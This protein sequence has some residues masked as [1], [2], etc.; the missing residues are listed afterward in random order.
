MEG[1]KYYQ[2]DDENKKVCKSDIDGDFIFKIYN[3]HSYSDVG[4]NIYMSL[5]NKIALCDDYFNDAR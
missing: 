3:L 5:T 1:N 4:I 2:F